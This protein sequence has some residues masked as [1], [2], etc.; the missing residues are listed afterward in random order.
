MDVLTSLKQSCSIEDYK[1]MSKA[2]SN[3]LRGVS[4]SYKL[5]WFLNGLRLPIRILIPYS[6]PKVSKRVTNGEKIVSEGNC[7]EM[8]FRVQGNMFST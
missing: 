4:Y 6:Q 8:K 2:L 3:H 1:S 5:S 7:G